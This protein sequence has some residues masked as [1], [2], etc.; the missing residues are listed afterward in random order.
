MLQ[1]MA[2]CQAPVVLVVTM[3]LCLWL[4]VFVAVIG[5]DLGRARVR[6]KRITCVMKGQ[7]G[8]PGTGRLIRRPRV[9]EAF[10]IE[11]PVFSIEFVDAISRIRSRLCSY[12]SAEAASVP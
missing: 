2:C 1:H 7:Y 11:E 9:E 6:D 4:F 10:S 8:Q 12:L 3:H 5:L